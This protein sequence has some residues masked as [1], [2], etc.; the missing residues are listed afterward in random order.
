MDLLTQGLAGAAL[1]QSAARPAHVRVAAA[2]GAVAGLLPDADV[3]LGASEDPLR[4]LELHRHF[5]H[6]LLIAPVGALLIAALAWPLARGRLRFAQVYVFALLGVATAG[7][8][9]ACTSF[10][11]HLL[12]PFSD[13]RVAWNLVAVVDPLLSL[14]L[15]GGVVL[16]LRRRSVVPARAGVALALAY[17]LVALVQRERAEAAATA[18]AHA[19]GHRPERVEVKPTMGNVVLWRS[20]YLAGDRFHVAAIR[21]GWSGP[22]VYPGGSAARVDPRALPGVPEGSVLARDVARF[23]RIAEGHLIRHPHRPEVLGDARYSM[24]PNGTVPLWGI[25]VDPGRPG[26]HVELVTFRELNAAVRRDFLDMLRGRAL[27]GASAST[28]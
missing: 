27:E 13:E 17:L 24:L 10:G 9:D 16:A 19:R 2:I 28:D 1:A 15:L 3:A 20:L 14:A 26:R 8:T 5:T 18:L 12:W 4:N 7:V 11:T 23:D 21:P 22:R 25:T 6:A